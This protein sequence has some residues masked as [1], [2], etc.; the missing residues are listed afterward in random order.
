MYAN[1]DRIAGVTVTMTGAQSGTTTTNQDGVYKFQP[2]TFGM[3]YTVTPQKAGCAFTPS[4]QQITIAAVESHAD[5]TAVCGLP[6]VTLLS[7]LN[8]SVL[9]PTTPAVLSWSAP[10]ATSYD[11]Y[12]GASNPPT[13]HVGD[14]LADELLQVNLN[15]GMT[16]YWKVV[17][18][19]EKGTGE[20]AVW[21]FQTATQQL[22]TGLHFVPLAP[23]RVVDTR[24]EEGKLA[25]FGPDMILG[26]TSR[27]FPI[28]T[29]DAHC[30]IPPS[31]KAVSA[32][33]TVVPQDPWSGLGYLTLWPTGRPQ[34]WVST[35]N[36]HDGRVVANAAIIP[37]GD[38]YSISAF[39]ANSTHLVIDING[40]F[41][42]QAGQGGNALYLVDPCRF[43]DTNQVAESLGGG[44]IPGWT[45]RAFNLA[46]ACG[47][48][49]AATRAAAYALNVTATPES[50]LGFLT[51]WPTGLE[52]PWVSTLNS[53]DGSPVANFAI[54]PS[55]ADTGSVSVFAA[56]TS[57]VAIDTNGYFAP[58]GA[59]GALAFHPITPCRAVDTRDGTGDAAGI[60]AANSTRSYA[61]AT[62]TNCGETIPVT[63]KAFAVNVT[64]QPTGPLNYISLFPAGLAVPPTST[65]SSLSGQVQAGSAIVGAGSNGQM[66]I[67]VA[68]ETHL[69]VDVV[70]YFIE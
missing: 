21:S 25:P 5:F 29:E 18:T 67:F 64:V 36:S 47:L 57:H 52:K 40:Y 58:S 39:A 7:P 22:P 65:L 53:H 16:Y 55:G 30:L 43:I 63:A 24:P 1:G 68:N 45:D 54:V 9:D 20:S 46:G 37:I 62:L 38:N 48:P 35:L 14:N 41:D 28:A 17:A 33:V 12:L 49:P 2:V 8:G 10:G 32:N 6:V 42:E 44:I 15:P 4:S 61:L 3:T 27:D 23:C 34:P 70:G 19:N 51:V 56:N 13:T 66:S 59:S 31:A 60:A 69:I 11:V 26:G 50:I